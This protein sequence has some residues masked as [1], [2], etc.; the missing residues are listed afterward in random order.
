MLLDSI[1]VNGQLTLGENIADLGGVTLSYHAYLR[2][3][4][5]A[6]SKT[7]DGFSGEQRFFIA[8][9]QGWKSK[10]RD[11]ELKRLLSMDYHAPAYIRAFVPL[12]NLKEFYEAFGIKPGDKLY[13]EEKDRVEIW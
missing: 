7:L 12:T 1:N 10:V 9:A 4:G 11:E 2:S 6:K 13:R 8:W 5:T 3:L